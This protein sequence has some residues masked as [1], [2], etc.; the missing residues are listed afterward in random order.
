MAKQYGVGKTIAKVSRKNYTKIIDKLDID[1]ALNPVNITASNILKY[2]RGGKVVS[3][4][5]LLGEMVR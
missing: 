3:V 4:S 1:A 2:V 5:L